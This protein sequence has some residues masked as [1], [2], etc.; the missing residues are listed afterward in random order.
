MG[1]MIGETLGNY[2]VLSAIGRGGMGEVYMAEH[3]L[4][5]RKVAIKVLLRKLS[6]DLDVV[7]RFF[8]EARA[9]AKLQHPGLVEVFDFGHHSDGSAYIVMELL[10][11]ESLAD[12]IKR[13]KRFAPAVALAIT[14]QVA[15]ALEAAHLQRIVHRDLKPENIFLLPDPEAPGGARV[16]VLDFGIAKLAPEETPGSVKTKTGAVFGTPRYMAPE[17]CKNSGN[18]DG[19]ADLYALGCI[20]FEMLLGR[21]PFDLDSWGELVAAHIHFPPKRLRELDPEQSEAIEAIVVRMLAK[22]PGDRYASMA[23]LAD[24]IEH[25]WRNAGDS[26]EALFTPPK[27]LPAHRGPAGTAPTLPVAAEV[28]A[29]PARSRRLPWI[30]L[31]GIAAG[32]IA[33]GAFVMLH[34]DSSDEPRPPPAA[35]VRVVEQPAPPP[36]PIDAAPA[37]PEPAKVELVVD[38]VP[39]GAD[40]Y[41]RADGVK[42]GKTPLSRAFDRVEGGEIELLVKHAGYHDKAVSLSTA[43]DGKELVKLV[44]S[45]SRPA[46]HEPAGSA[47]GK[48]TFLDPYGD[49]K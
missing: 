18:V 38:S 24:A 10:V 20:L 22:D 39:P 1:L 31:G 48:P 36:A 34:G 49:P 3:T 42:L 5:G 8:N 47:T 16:K 41:R 30:V 13:E 40:V 26:R 25:V 21:P 23:E 27:G 19:R 29:A 15:V 6:V 9:A 44:P 11:G 32:A 28:T 33:A 43:R 7:N 14:R 45:R 2:R 37:S 17:Q 46:T 12:R 35:P 4:I